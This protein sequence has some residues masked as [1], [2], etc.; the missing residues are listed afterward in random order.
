MPIICTAHTHTQL[1]TIRGQETLDTKGMIASRFG[2]CMRRGGDGGDGR[3]SGC[4]WAAHQQL[5]R[6][7]ADD[8]VVGRRRRRHG[9]RMMMKLIRIV[10]RLLLLE[11]VELQ[12]RLV[13]MLRVVEVVVGV[14]DDVHV[15]IVGAVA[16]HGRVVAG[17]VAGVH[18]GHQVA[19]GS[20]VSGASGAST[21]ASQEE[22]AMFASATTRLPGQFVPVL[23][24]PL[25]PQTG[26]VDMDAFEGQLLLLLFQR[27]EQLLLLAVAL[28]ALQLLGRNRLTGTR[29]RVGVVGRPP[30]TFLCVLLL[31]PLGST[32]LEPHLLFDAKEKKTKPLIII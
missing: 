18:S 6:E 28:F 26:H 29:L 14:T 27:L 32:V 23:R 13:E 15:D 11:D 31:A 8:P 7:M 17:R 10:V 12:Q 2:G 25:G 16:A 5:D 3:N 9:W 4:C 19:A 24:L 1:A 21:S 20:V 30:W 22:L